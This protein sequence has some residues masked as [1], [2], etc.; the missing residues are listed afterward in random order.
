MTF[1]R[2]ADWNLSTK[3]TGVAIAATLPVAAVFVLFALPRAEQSMTGEKTLGTKHLIEIAYAIVADYDARARKGEFPIAEAQKRAAACIQQLRYGEN[4]YFWI[5]D[6]TPT[7]I[8]HPIKPE[9]VGKNVAD[10]RDPAGKQFMIEML[11]VCREKG[12][13][14]VEYSW[15]KPGFDKP[16]PKISYVRL[17]R[18]WGWIIGSGVYADEIQSEMSALLR[19]ILLG[20]GAAV[21]TGIGVGAF[22]GH[23]IRSRLSELVNRMENADLNTTITSDHNDE[24]GVLTRT[25]DRFVG[26]IRATILDVSESTAAVASASAEISS[27]TD[28]IAAGAHEQATQAGEVASAVEEMTATIV[29]NSRNASATAAIAKSAREAAEQGGRAVEETVAAM[30]RIAEVVGASASTVRTLGKSSDQIGEIISVIDDI[31]DQTNLLALNAAIEAARAGEQGRGFA[32]VADEVRKLAERTTRATKEI[33]G[34]IT[35]IQEDTKGAVASIEKGTKNV[36]EGISLADRA[37]ASLRTIVTNAQKVTDMISQIA[38]ASEQQ[39]SAS[40]Q[41]ARNVES[42]SAVTGETAL[43]AEQISKSAE[44]LNRLTGKLQELVSTF[45]TGESG[46]Q[47]APT[48]GNG[49]AGKVRNDRYADR[50]LHTSDEPVHQE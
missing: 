36:A 32:V 7:M 5:N 41:I 3:I 25:F 13:G 20:L 50:V 18:P 28:Q 49:H 16:V 45:H 2:F 26:S 1:K 40:G 34:M 24:I 15:P 42:I 6:L 21:M 22:A 39:S 48:Q 30:R 4:E 11:K 37:G 27:S 33:A 12:E 43:G 38:A 31:A 9:L 19:S 47:S 23:R 46:R 44:D 8:M 17:Y 14:S 35:R 10:L 29:E